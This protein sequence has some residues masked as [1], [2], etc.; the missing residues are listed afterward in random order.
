[1]ES[2]GSIPVSEEYEQ[3]QFRLNPG[4][5]VL[6]QT[7]ERVWIP[8]DSDDAFTVSTLL[9]DSELS[10]TRERDRFQGQTEPIHS[11]GALGRIRRVLAERHSMSSRCFFPLRARSQRA[12]ISCRFR[13]STTNSPSGPIDTVVFTIRPRT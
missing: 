5:F 6:G 7:L 9:D 1:M 13:V 3:D 8:N 11:G 12:A 4:Q 10:G 2:W